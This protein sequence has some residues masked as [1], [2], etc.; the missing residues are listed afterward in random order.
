MLLTALLL[1][2]LTAT[3]SVQAAAAPGKHGA[4]GFWILVCEM[5][6]AG[7]GEPADGR[8]T[9]RL[10]PQS[11]QERKPGHVSFGSNLCRSFSC[12]SEGERMQGTISSASLVLTISLDPRTRRATWKTAGASGLGRTSGNCSVE[13]EAARVQ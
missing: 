11:F 6:T 12:V 1:S 9:F 4:S 3:G 10:G 7:A 13:P 8:R 2:G 5:P